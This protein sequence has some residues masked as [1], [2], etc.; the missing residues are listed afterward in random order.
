[1]AQT[2]RAT[3]RRK[4]SARTSIEPFIK[5]IIAWVGTL[6]ILGGLGIIVNGITSLYALALAG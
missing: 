5:G 2:E 3:R 4:K 6:A 1:M